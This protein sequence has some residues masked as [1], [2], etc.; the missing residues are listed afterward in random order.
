MFPRI[1]LTNNT[2]PFVSCSAIA[3]ELQIPVEEVV[4]KAKSELINVYHSPENGAVVTED[5]S[6]I[7]LE[8]FHRSPPIVFTIKPEDFRE[9]D[10]ARATKVLK[11]VC[12]AMNVH[13]QFK[14]TAPITIEV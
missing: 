6:K 12:K 11:D 1:Y 13:G 8:S 10:L 7:I 9:F 2:V 14:I 4:R 5:H 3:V